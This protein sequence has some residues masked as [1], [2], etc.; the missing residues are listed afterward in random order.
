MVKWCGWEGV[1]ISKGTTMCQ[2]AYR[3]YNRPYTHLY[4]YGFCG[5]I[6]VQLEEAKAEPAAAVYM[7][8]KYWLL[9]PTT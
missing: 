9:P 6:S 8:L 3:R 1:L 5:E 2:R 7:Y 4:T